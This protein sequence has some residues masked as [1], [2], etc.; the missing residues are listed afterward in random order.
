MANEKLNILKFLIESTGQEFS[1]RQLA[2]ARKI[3]YKSAYQNIMTL[4]KERI[5]QIKK[6][7]NIS[8]CSFNQNFNE[9]VYLVEYYRRSNLLKNK[10]FKILY[11]RLQNL[12]QQFILLLFGSFVK[13]AN[14][15]HSDIDLL[16]ISDKPKVVENEIDLLP[17]NIHLTS[18]TYKDFETMLESRKLTVVSEAIKNNILLFGIEDYYRMMKNAK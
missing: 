7:G 9:N 1:I 2:K 11:N 6:Q 3:N 12:N 13:K 4:E 17:L 18:I 10:N 8:L 16:L 15:K 14:S 5:V